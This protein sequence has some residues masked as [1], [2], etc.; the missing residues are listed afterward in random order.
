MAA[1]SPLLEEILPDGTVLPLVPAKAVLPSAPIRILDLLG[2]YA[3]PSPRA[4]PRAPPPAPPPARILLLKWHPRP[5]CGLSPVE[6]PPPPLTAG[7]DALQRTPPCGSADAF[8]PLHGRTPTGKRRAT[9]DELDDDDAAR[10]SSSPPPPPPRR[11]RTRLGGASEPVGLP[12][13]DEF[14]LD[15][16]PPLDAPAAPPACKAKR[17]LPDADVENIAS[18]FGSIQLGLWP[19]VKAARP[20]A[21]PA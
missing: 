2:G 12:K 17:R 15:A 5:A 1:S 21:T 19:P 7:D 18:N 9:D 3:A 13:L 11:K 14:L 16:L 8:A 4:S 10:S 20:A 6:V